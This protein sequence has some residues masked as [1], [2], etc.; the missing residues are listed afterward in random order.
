MDHE[1]NAQ[2][3]VWDGRVGLDFRRGMRLG[4]TAGASGIA[5]AAADSSP[6]AAASAVS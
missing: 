3:S 5:R 6:R 4:A 2:V 1:N